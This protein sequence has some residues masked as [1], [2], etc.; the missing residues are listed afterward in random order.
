[1]RYASSGTRFGAKI[2]VRPTMSRVSRVCSL[3]ALWVAATRR[4]CKRR[5]LGRGARS[6]RCAPSGSATVLLTYTLPHT[7][8]HTL[9]CAIRGCSR[10]LCGI[11]RAAF[12]RLSTKGVFKRVRCCLCTERSKQC[13]RAVRSCVSGSIAFVGPTRAHIC[14]CFGAA[15]SMLLA[16]HSLR[17]PEDSRGEPHGSCARA[18]PLCTFLPR[19]FLLADP[20]L[21]GGLL[22]VQQEVS[23]MCSATWEKAERADACL[24][25]EASKAAKAVW[26]AE[27]MLTKCWISPREPAARDKGEVARRGHVIRRARSTRR[28]EGSVG[29]C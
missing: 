7:L 27:E 26:T 22:R 10:V 17:T 28:R 11:T 3:G 12:G 2:G 9:I 1:M 19:R 15:A 21:H 8:P 23:P 5:A 13:V 14:V 18:E 4:D 16:S 25:M 24:A 20:A 6:L 29:P